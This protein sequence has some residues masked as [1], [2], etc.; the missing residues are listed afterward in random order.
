MVP[1]VSCPLPE[2]DGRPGK[3][4]AQLFQLNREERHPLIEIIV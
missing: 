4:L 1:D 3:K 2:I